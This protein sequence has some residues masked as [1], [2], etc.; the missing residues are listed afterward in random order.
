MNLNDRKQLLKMIEADNKSS[1]MEQSRKECKVYSNDFEDLVKQHL[2]DKYGQITADKML[3]INEINLGKRTIDNQGVIY[4]EPPVRTF[5]G[6]SDSQKKAFESIY[7]D[8]RVNKKLGR[9]NKFFKNQ[10]QNIMQV[11]PKD[12][13][14]VMR[15][16]KKHQ[17]HMFSIQGDPTEADIYIIPNFDAMKAARDEKELGKE[18]AKKKACKYA[19]WTREINF[20]MDGEG[21]VEDNDFAHPVIGY[22][23]FI[24]AADDDEKDF[25]LW[26][27]ERSGVAEFT[28][29]FNA[30]LSNLYH[31]MDMQG[32]SQLL[33]KGPDALLKKM[34][35][36]TVGVGRAL[37]LPTD[38]S[39]NDDEHPEID[40]S[41]ITASPDLM[42]SIEVLKVLLSSFLNSKG[43]D[44][45]T[46]SLNGESEGYSSGWERLLALI[47]KFEAT[48]D[49]FEVY[50]SVE[51][52][53]FRLVMAWH[54]AL[55]DS[56]QLDKKYKAAK[57]S[58]DAG[59]TIKYAE[60]AMVETETEKTD[61]IIKKQDRGY[62]SYVDAVAK[63][64]GVDNESAKQLI[65]KMK[66]DNEEYPA[67]T[68]VATITSN[69]ENRDEQ[70]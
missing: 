14:L 13:K 61:K 5:E 55:I 22:L 38:K 40:A 60:P 4:K 45:K 51:V 48:K 52:Q 70:A 11:L 33:I 1:R 12:G 46:V 37:M 50:R 58:N 66:K 67:L 41:F 15:V 9:S 64:H 6:L 26:T 42:G 63:E 20:I 10:K 21:D 23:P 36:M 57:T 68:S 47:E 3:V 17:I 30:A 43:I 29:K 24:E 7:K 65:D 44:P 34:S 16:F 28:V 35:E 69:I 39:P 8:M 18:R 19:V 62:I 32:W 2:I 27:D 59:M 53:L 54:N 56:K 31:I 49:D 25:Q